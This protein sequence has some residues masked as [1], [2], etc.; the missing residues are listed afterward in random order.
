MSKNPVTRRQ[1]LSYTLTGVGGFMA[2]GMLMPMLR[3]AVDPVL[4]PHAAGDFKMTDKKIAD[5]TAEPVRVDF[6]Y[7]QKDAWHTA[8]VTQTAWVY[9]NEAGE[10]VALSPICKH[11]GCTVSWEG[12]EK[13]PHMFFCP[14]HMGLYTKDGKN[15]PGTPP[16]GPLDAYPTQEK[17]GFLMLGSPVENPFVR[18]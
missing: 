11:L 6:K 14:C 13:H 8:D 12:S 2:A 18:K 17:D 4:Q 7:E 15:V 5:I 10:I 9:K 1:F 16:R 3:F